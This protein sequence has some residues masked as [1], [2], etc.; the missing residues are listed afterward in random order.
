MISGFNTD[1]ESEGRRFHVQSECHVRAFRSLES[2]VFYNGEVVGVVE[3]SFSNS[4]LKNA[5]SPEEILER[6]LANQHK[7]LVTVVG[8]GLVAEQDVPSPPVAAPVV[9]P[10]RRRKIVPGLLLCAAGLLIGLIGFRLGRSTSTPA[11]PVPPLVQPPVQLSAPA[12]AVVDEPVAVVAEPPPP[13]TL[14]ATLP[15]PEPAPEPVRVAR[16][17]PDP[18]PPAVEEIVSDVAP[19]PVARLQPIQPAPPEPEPVVAEP[20]TPAVSRVVAPPPAPEIF[21]LAEGEYADLS[22][23]ELAPQANFRPLP[24]YSKKARKKR[25]QGTVALDLLIDE[26]GEVADV[27]IREA[28][29]GS[30][31]T[32]AAVEAARTWRFSPARLN[33]KPIRVRKPVQL[34]FLIESGSTR[35]RVTK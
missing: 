9:T 4:S 21:Q 15:L 24:R 17:L 11:E 6:R 8:Q 34:Q 1:V 12:P 13:A 32:A 7:Q 5:D 19:E 28:I 30:Q 18:L 33:G 2:I 22:D 23:V 31:L 26:R 27:E 20:A 14:P 10:S 35:V 25:E 3:H 29:V 16:A